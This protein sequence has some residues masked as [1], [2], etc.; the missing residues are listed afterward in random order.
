MDTGD[1][2]SIKAIISIATVS[3]FLFALLWFYRYQGVLL[4]L[5][6]EN[7]ASVSD[8]TV[9]TLVVMREA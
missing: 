9:V 1:F 2:H 6:S 7:K 8:V 5:Y 3:V 4:H